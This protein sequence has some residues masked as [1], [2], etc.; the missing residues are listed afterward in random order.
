VWQGS[1]FEEHEIEVGRR[2]AD[3]IL[4]AKGLR[5]GE[6]VALSDPTNKE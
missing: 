5:G 2:S 1:Q 6:K 4:I 3:K